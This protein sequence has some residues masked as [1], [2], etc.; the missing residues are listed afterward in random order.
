MI[1][2]RL[3]KGFFIVS[4]VAILRGI[5]TYVKLLTWIK[6]IIRLNELI[7]V[8]FNAVKEVHIIENLEVYI[9][10]HLCFIKCFRQV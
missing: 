2:K 3:E 5:R 8:E 9:I 6:V 10:N 7:H 1:F 4:F